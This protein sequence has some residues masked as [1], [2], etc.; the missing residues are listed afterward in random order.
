MTKTETLYA[1]AITAQN[2]SIR[3]YHKAMK[4]GQWPKWYEKIE[5]SLSTRNRLSARLVETGEDNRRFQR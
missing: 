1:L 3:A 4:N 5:K 2:D